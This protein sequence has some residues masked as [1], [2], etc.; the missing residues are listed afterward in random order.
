MEKEEFESIR[1]KIGWSKK[2]TGLRLGVNRA[3]V[4]NYIKYGKIPEPIAKLMQMLAEKAG[5]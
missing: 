4:H 1:V 3:S 2:E 5:V